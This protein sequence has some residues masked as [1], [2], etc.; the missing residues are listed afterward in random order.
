[1]FIATVLTVETVIDA[2]LQQ[3]AKQLEA[4]RQKLAREVKKRQ[5][6]DG[7]AR[8]AAQRKAAQLAAEQQAQA[9]AKADLEQKR[10]ERQARVCFLL[11]GPPFLPYL[12]QVEIGLTSQPHNLELFLS[13][14]HARFLN[15]CTWARTFSAAMQ[16]KATATLCTQM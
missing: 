7:I 1:M 15:N 10:A 11:L 9:Q 6:A 12:K 14:T 8:M 3:E 13:S 2:K 4:A 5:E 16:C